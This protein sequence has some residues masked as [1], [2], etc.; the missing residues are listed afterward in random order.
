M[1]AGPQFGSIVAELPDHCVMIVRLLMHL[2]VGTHESMV[3]GYSK[4][5]G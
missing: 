1:G 2:K 5:R 3:F 4:L